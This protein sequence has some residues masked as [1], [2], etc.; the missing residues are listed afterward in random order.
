MI[1]VRGARAH[2]LRDVDVR[3]P[4][5]AITVITGVSGS[6]KS[7]LAFDTLYAEGQ[8]Q[9]IDSLSTYARQYLDVIPRPD[10]D[11][12]EG[13]APTLA[14]DQ[15]S[16][17]R[18]GRSTVATVTE[19]Y[20][21][22]RLLFARVGTQ[23]CVGCGNPISTQTADAIVAAL[24]QLDEGTKLTLM[25]PMVRGRKGAHK[26]VLEKIASHGLNRVRVDGTVY[27]LEEVPKLAVRKN[28]TIE[29]VVDRII[30]R[31]SSRTRLDE[32]TRLAI[33][34]GN[35]MC[36][37]LIDTAERAERSQLMNTIAACVDCGQSFDSLEPRSF[38]FNSP[39]GACSTCNG[40]GQVAQGD[41]QVPCAACDGRRLCKASLAVTIGGMAIDQLCAMP[42]HAACES[43]RRSVESLNN[44]ETA[45][46]TPIVTE[47][48]KR[49][50]FLQQVGV[51]YLT[52]DRRAE[53][54][55]GGE[56][57]RVR[58]A[59]SIGSGLVGVCYV[60]DEPSIGLHPSDHGRLLEAIDR[61]REAGNTIVI[62]EHDADTIR[63]ADHVIDIGPGAGTE[64]GHLV[65]EGTQASIASS[66]NSV[67]G[68]YLGGTAKIGVTRDE[69]RDATGYIE[70][71]G[72]TTNNL[73]SVDLQLPL[74]LLVGV[75]GVS[76]SG[77]SSLV[78]DTLLPAVA[79]QL[80]LLA[81]P[82][83]T[84]KGLKGVE[85]ID[86]L[87]PIDQQPIGRSARSCPATYTGVMDPIRKVFASTRQAKT[88]GYK[89]GRFSF[90]SGAGRC[91]LCK[92][93]G[94]ER[95][96]MNFLSDLL[97][98]CTRCGGKRFNRQTLSVRFK[99]ASIADVLSMTIDQAHQ[100]FENVP[101][102]ETP[103]RALV[104]VGLGYVSLGQT[105]TTLSGGEAQRIKLATELARKAS[106]K[107]LYILDE[108]T[109]GLHFADVQRLLIVLDRLVQRGNSVVVIEHHMELLA[110]FD[111]IID[112]GP[113]G[114]TMG[115]HI[116]AEGTPR[117]VADKDASLTGAAL[118][119]ALESR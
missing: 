20:D 43:L 2:N 112:L 6:G 108:P 59:T 106:G 46:A 80:E 24:S 62:V 81:D 66:A 64:G 50:G 23:H 69:T 88:L 16:S 31:A 71:K 100:F 83:S 27:R 99:G 97:L 52:L 30:V 79:Q 18:G 78:I 104:D 22:L 61:L 1:H 68:R 19:I 41:A 73:K 77:K 70:L 109:T 82:P 63:A 119:K 35:G 101:A 92:G 36:S 47:I 107:T 114:G 25:A 17:V 5:Q 4:H 49:I 65:A 39:Y 51:D 105:S 72:V 38:S 15:K 13:L 116:I 86:K 11:A 60:L 98:E 76:G 33:R 8:R 85:Q 53:T 3:I 93:N 90:N 9:F 14:I 95:V 55:S 87:V 84:F 96:E 102:A 44:L 37:A 75:S 67:T 58:L 45:V 29:A 74:G 54:L 10:V 28:H 103:L 91:D 34:L 21:Y 115:G 40:L 7:S 89:S 94:F 111:H 117:Q 113:G 56:L 57:Q 42:L 26:D 110:A 118:R 32:S 48:E 12:I